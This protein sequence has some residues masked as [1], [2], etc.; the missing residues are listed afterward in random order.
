M[1][2][3]A[4]VAFNDPTPEGAA[5]RGRQADIDADIESLARDPEA[6]M[7]MDQLRAEGVPIEQ[8]MARLAEHFRLKERALVS[9]AE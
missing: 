5:H 4:T 2:A 8:R 9:A 7:L 1:N 3:P 6:D